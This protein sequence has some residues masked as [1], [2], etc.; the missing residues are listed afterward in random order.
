MKSY[1]E[2]LELL[3]EASK[4]DI[5]K[6][7]FKLVRK[8]PPDRF[9]TEFMNIRE[10]YETLSNDKTRKQY[11]SINYLPSDIKEN[12]NLARTLMQEGDLS[13]A[14][15][16][17]EKIVKEYS[18]LLIVKALLGEAYLKNDNSGKSIKIY[19]ELTFLEPKNAAFAGY[20]ANAYL[21]RGFQKKAILAYDRAIKLDSDNISLWIGL[22]RAYVYNREYWNARNV[23]DKA[24]D[25]VK[26][27]DV[28][29]T[30]Y[31]ELIM[32]DINFEMF[33]SIHKSLDKLVDIVVNN[34]EVKY[35]VA[36]A[37]SHL[38]S[39]LI[40]RG[41]EKEAIKT[42]ESAAKILPEDKDIL[43][44]KKEIINYTTYNDVFHK[45]K[46]DK[47]I[48]QEVVDLVA[49]EVI[50]GSELGLNDDE[51]KVA[52]TNFEEYSILDDYDK[53]KSS[54]RKLEKDYPELYALKAEFFNKLKDNIGRKKLH[55]VYKKEL[56]KYRNI[57]E[58]FFDLDDYEDEEDGYDDDWHGYEPQEPIVREEA[59]VGRNDPCPC[60]S[61]KKYKKCCGKQ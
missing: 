58:R 52:M 16:I 23:L 3:P 42:I 8:Y 14:I 34:D 37:L 41:R 36:F 50:V 13:K 11:D 1:Y 9:E 61:G 10:A 30:I 18:T 31:L 59:K 25:I 33:S 17:L 4:K 48:K 15:K 57:L 29:S 26:D 7:Y 22:S 40:Q 47:K 6:A 60:G 46:K 54:I 12:Y 43:Q 21:T 19:E 32:L 5:K 56:Y 27:V 45:M 55:S 28:S 2:I 35:N 49:I 24:L 38:A 44:T 20:L 51:E 53:Y 39:Y